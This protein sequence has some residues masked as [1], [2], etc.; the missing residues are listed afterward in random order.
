MNYQFLQSYNFSP[1]DIDTLIAPTVQEIQEILS[2]DWRK[3]VL[4]TM[5]TGLTEETVRRLSP[6]FTTALMIAPEMME[7]SYVKKIRFVP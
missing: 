5:G 4:Y 1:E 6:A 3:T 2:E 7:D